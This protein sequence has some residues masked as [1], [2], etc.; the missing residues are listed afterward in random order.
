MVVSAPP[1]DCHKSQ[2]LYLIY[3]TL[4]VSLYPLQRL[5]ANILYLAIPTSLYPRACPSKH[6]L[7]NTRGNLSLFPQCLSSHAYPH[8]RVSQ[9]DLIDILARPAV[10]SAEKPCRPL[11]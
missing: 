11:S 5:Y 7:G 3:S 2:L 6:W 8:L 9:V 10:V 1:Q 4:P